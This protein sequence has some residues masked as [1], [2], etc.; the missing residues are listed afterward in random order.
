[1]ILYWVIGTYEL[2]HSRETIFN[3]LVL[4]E[5]GNRFLAQKVGTIA[6]GI[7]WYRT[8]APKQKSKSP[9]HRPF[10][11]WLSKALSP[12]LFDIYYIHSLLIGCS[13]Y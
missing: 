11:N 6:N 13:I 1:M 12:V 9:L 2:A 10:S 8:A 7:P 5:M 4:H 3:Q